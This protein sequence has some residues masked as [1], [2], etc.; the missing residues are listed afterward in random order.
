MSA[1]KLWLELARVE[2]RDG[3]DPSRHI[4]YMLYEGV[5]LPPDIADYVAGRLLGQ[6][7]PPKRGVGRP[8]A[9][10]L[11][12]MLRTARLTMDVRVAQAEN[13]V[14]GRSPARDLAID[15][16]AERENLTPD[17]VRKLITPRGKEG[18]LGVIPSVEYLVERL[19]SQ[20]PSGERSRGAE[21][22]E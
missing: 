15:T 16:V 22:S 3:R 7:H 19:R 5:K 2:I 18:L 6:I 20:T 9:D 14:A 4:A 21:N 12:S 17:A 1:T 11:A 8:A 13:V 10:P